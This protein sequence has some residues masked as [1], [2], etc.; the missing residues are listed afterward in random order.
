MCGIVDAIVFTGGMAH[1]HRLINLISSRVGRMANIFV[2][3]GETEN[4]ALALGAYRVIT[5]EEEA[6]IYHVE[7]EC[8]NAFAKK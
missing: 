5:G 3:P 8:K 6:A 1:S 4:E 2:Y 7:D